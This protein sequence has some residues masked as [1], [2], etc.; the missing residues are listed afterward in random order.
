MCGNGT[1][2]K[3]NA[4]CDV[5]SMKQTRSR[6]YSECR[7][8]KE[9]MEL[10]NLCLCVVCLC[11]ASWF[12]FTRHESLVLPGLCLRFSLLK[13]NQKAM[14]ENYHRFLPGLP[15]AIL[16]GFFPSITSPGQLYSL[17]SRSVRWETSRTF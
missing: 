1:L 16:R 15:R 9:N 10:M 17:A 6:F 5:R 8:V 3:H 4:S 11:F 14:V 7:V 12:V 13:A 2:R